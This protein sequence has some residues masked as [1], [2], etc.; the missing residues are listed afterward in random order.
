MTVTSHAGQPYFSIL[1]PVYDTPDTVLVECVESVLA[2][3]RD[4]WELLLVDD[5]SPAPHIRGLLGR[6]A[7]RDPRIRVLHRS[8]NGGIVAA[9]NDALAA[10]TG[11]FVCLLDHDD[12][13]T[14]HALSSVGT[15]IE[16]DPTADLVYTD[17]DKVDDSGRH[18]DHFFKPDWS[19]ARLASHMYIGHFLAMRRSL[20]LA[21][22]GFRADYEGSQDYDLAL[23]VTEQARSV[24]HVPGVRYH[25]RASQ[26]STAGSITAKPYAV[27]AGGRAVADHLRRRG[28]DATVERVHEVGIWRVRRRIDPQPSVSI[29]IPS[30]GSAALVDGRFRT[31][32]VGAVRSI[33]ERSTYENYEVV[34]VLDRGTP[35][36]VLAEVERV[37]GDR[38]H[39]VWFDR[40]FN[41]SDKVNV[42]A[43][44]ASGEHLL[45]L[46]D[47][48]E[49]ISP[50]WIEALVGPALEPDVGMVGAKLYFA[51]GT[52]QHAGHHYDR[53]EALH[54]GL[55]DAA[56]D[57]G[58]LGGYLTEREACGVTAA[59][60]LVPRALFLGV[61]GFTMALPNNFNDVDFSMKI[62]TSGH[63]V[64]WTPH[65]RLFHYES[66]S[67]HS[68]V[69]A[70]EYTFMRRRWSMAMRRDPYWWSMGEP[71]PDRQ[72]HPIDRY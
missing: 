39:L 69:A 65:A 63:R 47:D 24:V 37:L 22:G 41:F 64:I 17:E 58:Y 48:T 27:E 68:A 32:L 67:R 25:W 55:G 61:G 21:V 45:L 57:P 13:L 20:V 23:R 71:A 31:L 29:V 53:Y 16:N 15:A 6:L 18:Y 54:I 2:Q 10:A 44:A 72:L 34:L 59:C 35:P 3:D 51:D 60:A 66:K 19:P 33:V 28:V 7:A 11:E 52:I 4:D 49:V 14:Y 1:T 26:T 42:G 9:S 12:L 46:N 36:Y 70:W 62:R 38:L 5:A 8:E 43:L 40:P 30:R 56:D 50:D